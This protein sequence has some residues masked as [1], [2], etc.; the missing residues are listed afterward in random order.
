[1]ARP[2]L[3]RLAVLCLRLLPPERAHRSA[4]RLI[5][6]GLVRPRREP[7]DAILKT[8]VFGL[9]FPNPV[10]L[11]AGFD[12]DAEVP[13]AMLALGLGFVEVGTVTPMPQPGN[14]RPRLFR[15]SEDRALIN[16]L[17]FNS[18]GLEAAA[19]RLAARTRARG[20]VGANLGKNKE[21]ADATADYVLGVKALAAYA[22]YLAIN[23]S[24]PNTPGLRA[25]QEPAALD[26]LVGAVMRARG[27]ATGAR[28]P[29]LL[30]LAPDLAEDDCRDIA[31]IALARG[32]DG[33]ILGNTTLERPPTLKSRFKGEAG[34]LSGPPLMALS[35]RVLAELYRR[36]EGRIPLIGVGGIASG[37]D[38][39]AKI[40]AGAALVAL[41]TALVYEGPGLIGRIKA[42]LAAL[43]RRDG[44]ASVADAVGA[45]HRS[46]RPS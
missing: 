10:G 25:L 40:R 20:I 18:G 8:R 24:S 2:D 45:D 42:E 36:S 27:E 39:Y 13:D 15:L 26:A 37:A 43:L 21:S 44:F 41:Y 22:D 35:T 31:R 23:V 19:R 11:A 46:T 5:G 38:A 33:L 12:K 32:I 16:R 4:I 28:P 9:D 6:S 34:G 7:D 29:V 30:K 17:G 3:A 14:P 1:M